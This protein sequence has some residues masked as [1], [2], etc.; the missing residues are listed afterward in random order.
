MK[1]HVILNK[2]LLIF[3]LAVLSKGAN[4][5]SF[6]GSA[7]TTSC[8]CT[9]TSTSSS[10]STFKTLYCTKGVKTISTVKQLSNKSIVEGSAGV[11][12]NI[13]D[14]SEAVFFCTNQPNQ[15]TPQG[16]AWSQVVEFPPSLQTSD[17]SQCDKKQQGKCNFTN[18]LNAT[19]LIGKP[20][21]GCVS[22]TWITVDVTPSNFRA[23]S[24]AFNCVDENGKAIA[25]DGNQDGI[26][27]ANVIK[28]GEICEEA[29]CTLPNPETLQW[30]EVRQYECQYP[31]P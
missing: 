29:A 14:V 24:C 9:S 22:P 12:L 5:L 23:S 10:C 31:S 16:N 28:K 21:E 4:A 13:T 6:G 8:T 2:A 3:I 17:K 30:M 19:D 25:C 26:V 18:I 15:G 7:G 20:S 1:T 27:D 11:W